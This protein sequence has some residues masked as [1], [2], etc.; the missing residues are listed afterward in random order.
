[1]QDFLRL[2]I[3]ISGLFSKAVEAQLE[4]G[5][6]VF[7]DVSRRS[8]PFSSPVGT[9]PEGVEP[10]FEVYSSPFKYHP[11]QQ[12]MDEFYSM[13]YV[14]FWIMFNVLLAVWS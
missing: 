11:N 1:M 3:L 2:L 7:K 4:G 9:Q 13:K 10:I 14:H 8:S 6:P 12:V 5:W